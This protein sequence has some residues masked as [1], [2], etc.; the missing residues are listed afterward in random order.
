ME[1]QACRRSRF[2]SS[3]RKIGDP[4]LEFSH[5]AGETR[6]PA[7]AGDESSSCDPTSATSFP[8]RNALPRTTAKSFFLRRAKQG[9]QPVSLWTACAL[10]RADVS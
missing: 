10:E 1:R 3:W 6:P 2:V 7:A 5:L 4:L 8:S 9:S